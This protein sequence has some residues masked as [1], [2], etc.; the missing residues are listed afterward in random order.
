MSPPSGDETYGITS[1]Q[2]IAMVAGDPGEEIIHRLCLEGR[3]GGYGTA[4]T[5]TL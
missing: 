4:I 2:A 3:S 1:L 5:G